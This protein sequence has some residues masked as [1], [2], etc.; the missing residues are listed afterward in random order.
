MALKNEILLTLIER[1]DTS[2]QATVLADVAVIWQKVLGRFSPLIGPSSVNVLFARSLD[3]NRAAFPWL[4]P[5]DQ[6]NAAEMPFSAF[7]A[8]LKIQSPDEVI[9]ATQALLGTY[10]DSLYTLIGRTLTE[11]FVG[12]AFRDDGDKKIDRRIR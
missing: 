8:V 5:S 2:A 9:R 1:V 3:A 12:S 11:Q 10:I 6:N 4:P 7:E